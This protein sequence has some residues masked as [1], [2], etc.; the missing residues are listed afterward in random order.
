MDQTPPR[1]AVYA[2]SFDPPTN[3]HVDVIAR[4]AR[5]FDHLIVAVG[6]NIQKTYLFTCDER[7]DILKECIHDLHNVSVESFDGLLVDFAVARDACAIVR[8]L[9]AMTDFD[10]EFQVGLANKAL[11]PDIETIF[12]LTRLG[13]IFISSSLIKEV[14]SFGGD[15]SPYLPA[16][17][18]R[19][20]TTRLNK[21]HSL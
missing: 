5:L 9:R 6:R 4:A 12:I 2:G 20:M 17:S 11:N 18:V 21:D 16:P 14:A 19:A 7:M 13:N 10:Y 1:I 15:V 3:G 8:G